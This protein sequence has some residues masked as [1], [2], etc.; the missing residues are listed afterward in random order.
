[1]PT[2]SEFVTLCQAQVSLVASLGASLSIVYLT[3]DWVEGGH[4]KLIPV[5]AYPES[6]SIN[7]PE[8]QA[9]MSSSLDVEDSLMSRPRLLG[10]TSSNPANTIPLVEVES[11]I[12]FEIPSSKPP[13]EEQQPL[14]QRQF[15]LPLMR[16]GVVM[17]FLVTSREDRPWTP[18]EQHQIQ[19]IAHTLTTAF[20]L[21][22]RLQ[23]L[24]Q[25]FTQQQKLQAQQYDTLHSLLHQLKSP[26][27]AVRTF[28][29]LLIKRLLPEDRNHKIADGILRE[30]D[31]IKELLE[32][33][34]HTLALNEEQMRLPLASD[35]V[36]DLEDNYLGGQPHP[37]PSLKPPG[38][39]PAGQFLEATSVQAVLEPLILS[40]QAIAEERQLTCI[41]EIPPQLPLVQA[42]SQGLREVLSNLIDNALKYTPPQGCISIRVHPPSENSKLSHPLRITISDTGPGIPRKDLEHLFERGYRGIQATGNIPGTGLGLAIARDLI[43]QMQ[44]E[45]QVFSP[46]NLNLQLPNLGQLSYPQGQG[47]TFVIGLK[48]WGCDSPF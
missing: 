6:S 40:A 43:K 24:Q 17:G 33:V 1:M 29:K 35:Q 16:D 5:A 2:R 46:V 21:N 39:L 8:S 11:R 3:E 13:L 44:A 34:D 30:S 15:V 4:R 41:T 19:V 31:R 22:R 26:L 18:Q 47:T 42:N 23:W 36:Q 27:T 45:I 32:Q 48:L 12:N 38:L 20:I 37:S 7:Q 10:P 25:Q 9:L 14:E 28:G